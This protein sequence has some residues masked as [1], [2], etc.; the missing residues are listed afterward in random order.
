MRRPDVQLRRLPQSSATSASRWPRWST[1]RWPGRLPALPAASVVGCRRSRVRVGAVVGGPNRRAFRAQLRVTIAAETP[2]AC[3][4]TRSWLTFEIESRVD[5]D[6]EQGW[7]DDVMFASDYPHH[8]A[9]DPGAVKCVKERRRAR[10]RSSATIPARPISA[11]A[12]APAIVS[13]GIS[14][15]ASHWVAEATGHRSRLTGVRST[16]C[17]QLP[18]AGS[19]PSGAEDHRFAVRTFLDDGL[20][21]DEVM[22][23]CGRRG[24]SG[25]D[26]RITLQR[27]ARVSDE[28]RWRSIA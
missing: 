14:R 10:R 8:D 12:F 4:G 11:A 7:A 24:R 15:S 2:T 19:R 21:G 26:Q 25:D 5:V 16:R 17:G 18:F 28:S 20:T 27:I 3:S 9:V 1:S 13:R 22:P 6:L 23:S